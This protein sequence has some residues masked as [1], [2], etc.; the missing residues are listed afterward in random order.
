MISRNSVTSFRKFWKRHEP[1]VCSN[2]RW[3]LNKGLCYTIVRDKVTYQ[4]GRQRCK[5]K[6]NESNVATIRSADD[7]DFV[8]ISF[9]CRDGSWIGLRGSSMWEDG[10][11]FN[12]TN[13]LSPKNDSNSNCTLMWG[14]GSW[15]HKSCDKKFFTYCSIPAKMNMCKNAKTKCHKNAAC[16][17]TFLTF[18]C[19]CNNGFVGDGILACAESS[20]CPS[21]KWKE[22]RGLCYIEVSSILTY[23]EAQRNCKQNYSGSRLAKIRFKNDATFI[24]RKFRNQAHWLGLK[25]T[26]NWTDALTWDDGSTVTYKSFAST[27]PTGD[28]DEDCIFSRYGHFWYDDYCDKKLPSFCSKAAFQTQNSIVIITEEKKED[29]DAGK[30]VTG[31]A[32][33]AVL[34]ILVIGGFIA[35]K[36]FSG[37]VNYNPMQWENYDVT[38]S[39]IIKKLNEKLEN[40]FY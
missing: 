14:Y 36:K 20:G 34:A 31:A 19:I 33:I 12:Y 18:V 17:N 26:N 2:P 24:R 16:Y 29:I 13:Y 3:K 7:Q 38:F 30:G 8:T 10:S 32:V 35:F 23:E 40:G 15:F 4:V 39:S 9:D 37:K 21:N 1:K 22:H 27:E 6:F 25:K 5:N 28:A 11:S